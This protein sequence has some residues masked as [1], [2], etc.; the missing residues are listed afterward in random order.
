ME[1]VHAVALACLYACDFFNVEVLGVFGA[2][3]YSVFFVIRLETREV[4]IAGMRVNPNGEWMKQVARNLT[5]PF[6]GFLRDA[7]YLVHDADPLFTAAFKAVLKPPGSLKGEG[8]TCVQIPPRSP[9]CNPHSERFVKSIK[10]ECLRNFVFF[11]ERH[12]RYVINEYMAHYHEERFHQGIGSKLIRPTS[13]ND[14][15]AAG[16]INCRSRLGGLLNFY[17]REAA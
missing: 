16:E 5:D 12:L 13:A 4:E 1:A 9:N 3:R 10:Y 11:G 2:V 6:D 14:N 7:R 8:V 15:A 17:Y